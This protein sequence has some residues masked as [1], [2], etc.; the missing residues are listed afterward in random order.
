MLADFVAHRNAVASGLSEAHVLALRAYTSACYKSLNGPLRDQSRTAPHPFPITVFLI[1]DA[2]KK[3]RAGEQAGGR[4]NVA[5]WRGMR[6]MRATA[7]FFAE[8]GSEI[9]PMSATTDLAVALRYALS[10]HSLLFKI[11][12]RSFMERGVDLSFLSC[13]PSEK[14]HLF[15]PLTYLRPTGNTQSVTLADGK[16]V[17]VVEVEPTFGT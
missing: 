10:A 3:L 11:T 7:E 1:A 13:F 16:E 15:P 2:L 17:E 4:A 5:L 14:E 12:T 9:A 6:D 8:G